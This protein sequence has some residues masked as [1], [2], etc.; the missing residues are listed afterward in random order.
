MKAVVF[1]SICYAMSEKKR[2]DAH[3]FKCQSCAVLNVIYDIFGTYIEITCTL[4]TG[5]R[6][7]L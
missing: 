6:A 2:F 4:D 5:Y 3:P 1:L 7:M